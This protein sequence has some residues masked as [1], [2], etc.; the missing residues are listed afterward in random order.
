MKAELIKT[1][2]K[3]QYTPKGSYSY[4]DLTELMSPR[5]GASFTHKKSH[6]VEEVFDL[7]TEDC[8]VKRI[9]DQQRS[10]FKY[11]GNETHVTIGKTTLLLPVLTYFKNKKR[12]KC[13]GHSLLSYNI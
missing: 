1:R 13:A 4:T 7:P 10:S 6:N 12:P 11:Y 9:L 2:K 3:I 5:Q 8:P